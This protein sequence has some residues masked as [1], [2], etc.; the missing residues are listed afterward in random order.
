MYL[1]IDHLP[2]EVFKYRPQLLPLP[3]VPPTSWVVQ[4]PTSTQK[5]QLQVV[6]PITTVA[7]INEGQTSLAT[8]SVYIPHHLAP[9]TYDDRPSLILPQELRKLLFFL[10]TTHKWYSIIPILN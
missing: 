10:M 7:A 9:S 4:R 2:P 1:T 8:S 6:R 5:Q 3:M